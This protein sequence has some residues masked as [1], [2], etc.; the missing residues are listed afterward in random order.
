MFIVDLRNAEG[1]PERVRFTLKGREKMVDVF[2][3]QIHRLFKN[4]CN[5]M[6]LLY[7]EFSHNYKEAAQNISR[8]QAFVQKL[9]TLADKDNQC[10]FQL[11]ELYSKYRLYFTERF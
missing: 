3:F 6:K 9:E 8:N 7:G 4:R 1:K 11:S 10:H 5:D 2:V